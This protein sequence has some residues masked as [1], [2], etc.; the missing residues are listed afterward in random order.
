LTTA[1]AE[2]AS[3][4]EEAAAALDEAAATSEADTMAE[5]TA[6]GESKTAVALGS[7]LAVA[8]LARVVAVKVGAPSAVT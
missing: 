7:L 5:V 4:L 1:V 2:A 6:A 3:A 8:V